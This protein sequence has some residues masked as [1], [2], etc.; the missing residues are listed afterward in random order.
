[1]C[2]FLVLVVV[3]VFGQTL[4]FKLLSWDDSIFVQNEPRVSPGFSWSGIVWAFT[5]GPLGDWYPL[6]M[7]SH[8]LDCQLYGL[9]PA[10]HHLTNL[11]LHAAS[12]VSLFL[13]LWR[14]TGGLWPRRWWRPCL[15]FIPSTSS[16]SPGWPNGVTC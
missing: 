12:A 5:N 4:G 9:R 1:M 6:A 15:P 8:M 13:V 10:G 16:R 7:L 2:G 11:L 14:M 3:V